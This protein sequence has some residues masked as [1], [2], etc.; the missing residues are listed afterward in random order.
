MLIDLNS[1]EEETELFG[2]YPINRI[3]QGIAGNAQFLI[4]PVRDGILMHTG[5]WPNWSPP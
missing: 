4:G 3:V 1:P 5:E 2:P